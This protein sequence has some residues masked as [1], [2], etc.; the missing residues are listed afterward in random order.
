MTCRGAIVGVGNVAI[1]GHLP[2][3]LEHR[4]VAIVAASDPCRTGERELQCHLPSVHWYDSVEDLL[5]AE[6]L[7]FVDICTPPAT[8]AGLVRTALEHRLHVLCEKPLV[9]RVEDLGGLVALVAETD[10]VLHTVHNWHH[11]PI[12]RWVRDLLQQDA[13]GEVRGCR[14][15]TLRTKPAAGGG[16][17][18]GNWRLDPATAGGGVLVDH[19]WHAFYVLQGWLGQAPARVSARLETRRFTQVPLED[20]A[21]VRL[22]LPQAAVE[23]YL[24][25]AADVR[26]NVAELHGTRGTM[27]VEDSTVVLRQEAS[28]RPERRWTFS[29]PLSEGSHHADWFAGVA[30][31]FV[32]AVSGGSTVGGGNLAEASLCATL[33]ALAQESS[34]QGGASLP[35]P[36]PSALVGARGAEEGKWNR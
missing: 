9:S 35:V 23:V 8:H 14:W 33:V 12:I 21:T 11:A 36:G 25:W 5:T 16:D 7:D 17:R 32:T 6:R 13:I 18:A 26:R 29:P 31:G 22:E 27:R 4:D 1:H 34:R 20:T 19:G 28:G 30:S 10:R 3:W 2:G 15:E 24:T